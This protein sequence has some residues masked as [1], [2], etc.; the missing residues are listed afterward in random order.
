V[1]QLLLTLLSALLVSCAVTSESY[2]PSDQLITRLE[3]ARPLTDASTCLIKSLDH[4]LYPAVRP[5]TTSISTPEGQR[6]TQWFVTKYVHERVIFILAKAG[7]GRTQVAI[8]LMGYSG[9]YE[10]GSYG[11]LSI[12]ALRRCTV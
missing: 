3:V 5:T 4:A 7:D 6:I 11:E 1:R 12:G 10:R 8:Y 2:P 9:Q